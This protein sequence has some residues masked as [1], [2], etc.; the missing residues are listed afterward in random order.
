MSTVTGTGQP[1]AWPPYK[2]SGA[3]SGAAISTSSPSR[4]AR[5]KQLRRPV[6]QATPS[7]SHQ[8]QQRVAVAVDPQLL[9][10]L[11][12]A[13]GLALAP[14]RVA[15]AAE[16]ADAA[17]GE[18]LR[19]GV[20][21]HPGEH[22]HL[23]G[24]VLLRDGGHQAGGVE[25][26]R[27]QYVLFAHG[28]YLG[29]EPPV[30]KG[31]AMPVIASADDACPTR[32]RASSNGTGFWLTSYIGANRYTAGA[33]ASAQP[34]AIYPVAFLVEQDAGRGGGCALSSGRPVPG[35]GRRQRTTRARMV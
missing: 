35:D 6:W 28:C 18:R 34:G 11:H 7:W 1:C 4:A 8:Q 26:D 20:A 24:V 13:G 16:V 14:Q 2:V 15:A 25:A 23:A 21:V 33:D 32:R 31:T 30:G 27:G 19:H 29:V 12:L 17:G 3:T 5:K 10:V 22:Q 9:Q